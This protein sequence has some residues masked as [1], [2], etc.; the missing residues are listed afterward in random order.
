M[1]QILGWARLWFAAKREDEGEAPLRNGAWYP[2]LSSGVNRAVLE[3]P[4]DGGAVPRDFVE[5]RAKAP[6]RFRVVYG[7][8]DAPTPA[9]AARAAAGRGNAW[10]PNAEARI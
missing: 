5:W 8:Y 6:D 1:E 2:I 9:S 7:P 4:G 10:C 3:G